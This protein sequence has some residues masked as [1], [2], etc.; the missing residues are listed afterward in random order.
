MNKTTYEQELEKNG[1]LIYTTVGMSMRPFLRSGEDMIILERRD[2][3]RFRPREVVLYRRK[4]GKYVLHRIMAVRKDDYILCGDNCWDLEPGIRG[5]QILAVLTGVIRNGQRLDV[6]AAGYRAKVFVWWLLYP[7][8]A[9]VFYFR[10]L[11]GKL[12]AKIKSSAA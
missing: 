4:S 1:V 11:T 5:E 7:I 9:V 2:N 10:Y 3:G 6:N 8:R 12:W